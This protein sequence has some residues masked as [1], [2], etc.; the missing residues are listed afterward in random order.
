IVPSSTGDRDNIAPTTWYLP[1][2]VGIP[3]PGRHRSVRMQR[4]AVYNAGRNCGYVAQSA[5]NRG[6]TVSVGTPS[7]NR[8]IRSQ[9]KSMSGTLVIPV[10]INSNDV[11]QVGWDV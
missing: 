3:T 5:G 10:S 4:H 11:R 6:L 1:L 8:A 9:R 7:N 2:T